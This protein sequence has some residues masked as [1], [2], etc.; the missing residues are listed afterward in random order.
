MGLFHA[1]LS[2]AGRITIN[3]VSCRDM[4]PDPEFYRTCLLEAFEELQLAARTSARPAK[5]KAKAKKK[6]KKKAGAARKKA[7]S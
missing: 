2:G 3:F 6:A 7:K 4:L 1:V 5:A